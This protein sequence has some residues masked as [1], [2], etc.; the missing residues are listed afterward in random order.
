MTGANI[1]NL[2]AVDP[3]TSGNLGTGKSKNALENAAASFASMLQPKV[4]TQPADTSQ[5]MVSGVSGNREYER[6]SYQDKK[7]GSGRVPSISDQ[8]DSAKEEMEQFSDDVVAAV[9][10]KLGADPDDVKQ[11]LD[12]L[13]MT[14]FDLLNPANLAQVVM[15]WNG[16]EDSTALL[17]DTDFQN[18][19]SQIGQLGGELM[20]QLHLEMN[21][22]NEL[23]A[24]MDV[25][26]EPVQMEG[27]ELPTDDVTQG[28]MGTAA[29]A[30][31]IEL[32]VDD[33]VE[34]DEAQMTTDIPEQ[35]TAMA[36]EMPETTADNNAGDNDDG[37]RS[38]K[39]GT[40]QSELT[41]P[42]VL[43]QPAENQQ[44]FDFTTEAVSQV[45]S[46]TSVDTMDL[47]EQVAERMRVL[48]GSDE[49][50][51]ELQLNPENLGKVYLNVTEKEGTIRAQIAAQNEAVKQALEV[52][53][54]DLQENLNQSG[55]KVTSIEI[56]I[57]THEFE[58]NLE[59]NQQGQDE[60]P[61]GQQQRQRRNLNLDSL[62]DLAGLMSEEETL[63]AQIMRDNGNSVDFTA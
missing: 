24:Q 48:A 27:L 25:L 1:A 6:Y 14:A 41:Q 37:Q 7:L 19:L 46:Y 34:T 49:T 12:E 33:A 18:L 22:M 5:N 52:Q 26:Q 51:M 3:M 54:A 31:A 43:T 55:M 13:G 20:N 59:Q 58:R 9:S 2:G 36:E 56:T 4:Q 35:T 44:V 11:L 29:S 32:P 63:V 16:S 15:Q 40:T 28:V 60:Q 30:D 47:I 50:S 39:Q 45:Q 23:I 53:L 57:A 8:V 17:L 61:D 38:M 21:Q 62:D 42:E 10:E